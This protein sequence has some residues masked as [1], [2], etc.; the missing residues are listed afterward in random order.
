MNTKLERGL[1]FFGVPSARVGDRQ[2]PRL[3]EDAL[4]MRPEMIHRFT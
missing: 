3:G 1:R 2:P 4:G